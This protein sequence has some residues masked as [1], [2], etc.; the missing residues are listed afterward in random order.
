MLLRGG[1]LDGLR[2]LAPETVQEMMRLQA[3]AHPALDEG[4]GLGFGVRERP[5]RKLAWWDGSLPGVASRF[6][7]L[8]EHGVGAV[9]LS[10]R[11]N[12]ATSSATAQRLLALVVPEQPLEP[13]ATSPEALAARAGT[14][15]FADVIDPDLFYLALLATARVSTAGDRLAVDSRAFGAGELIPVSDAEVFRLRGTMGTDSTVRFDGARLTVGFLT[16]HRIPFWQ[17]PLAIGAALAVA[18][19]ALLAVLVWGAVRLLRRRREVS[20]RPG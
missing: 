19:L 2:F 10:N 9:V 13:A 17:T 8:P 11:S 3:R 6:A 7:L 20:R 12:N 5:G 4:F 14:Y 15:R 18:G 1:E 16:A